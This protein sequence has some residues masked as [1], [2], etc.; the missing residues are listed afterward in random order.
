MVKNILFRAVIEVLGKPEEHVEKSLKKFVGN[1]KKDED[2]KVTSEDY[3]QIKKQDEQELWAGFA[4][5]E[6]STNNI[7]NLVRFCFDY[8][9]SM[10]EIIEPKELKLSETDLS[11]FLNS[12][13]ARLHNIDMVAK[14]VKFENDQLKRNMT[15]LLR[16]YLLV[17]LNNKSFSSEQLSKFTGVKQEKLEDYLDQLTDEGRVE[18]KDGVYSAKK[19]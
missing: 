5:I 16:N 2:F 7:D 17:L 14:Q 11:H 4:E 8:M 9:P 10:I 3:A 1:L 15:G 18:L 6:A 12:L 19:K 13:Q